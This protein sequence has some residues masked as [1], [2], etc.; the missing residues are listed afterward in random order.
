MGATT[1]S[2]LLAN[3]HAAAN[4]GLQSQ[5]PITVLIKPK[6][7]SFHKSEMPGDLRGDSH[8]EG[9]GALAKP[10]YSSRPPGSCNAKRLMDLLLEWTSYTVPVAVH[11]SQ[12]F[13]YSAPP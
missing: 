8:C 1:R 11:Q 9:P 12:G 13:E 6:A 7:P 3:R 5:Q 2:R 10:Q 4:R